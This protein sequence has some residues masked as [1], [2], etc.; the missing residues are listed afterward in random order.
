MQQRRDTASNWSSANPTL[1]AGEF[2]WDTTNSKLKVGDGS[3]AWNSLSYFS[4]G[5]ALTGG[6]MTGAILGDDSTSAA[7]PA[8]AF[9][10]DANTGMLRT[11]ADA[12]ALVTG[13][14]AAISIDSSQ[15][16]VIAGTLQVSG[17][18]TTVNSTTM[19]VADLNIEIAKGAAN[20]AAADGAGLTVDSGEGDKTWNWVNATDSWTSSEHIDIASGKVFKIATNTVLDANGAVNFNVTANNSTDETVYPVFVDGST[21]S[22][23]AETDTGLTYNPSTGTLTAT[24]FSGAFSGTSSTATEATNFTVTANNSTDESTYLVFVDG[25]TGTQGAET[26]TGLTYNPSSGNLSIGGELVAQSLDIS[27][28][29]DIDGILETDALTINGTTLSETIADTVG[30]MV[31]SNTETGITVTYEDSDNTLDFVIGTLNQDTTGTAANA[32]HVSVADNESTDENNLITFIENASATGNVGLESDGDFYY[33]PSTGRLTAT[34]LAGTLQTAAQ[35]NI[36]SVGSLTGLTIDGDLTFTGANYNV[37]W[38]KSDNALEFVDNAKAAFGTDGELSLFHNGSDSYIVDGGTGKLIIDA[39]EINFVKFGTS[40]VMAKFIEDGACESYFNGTKK[41]STQS[42]GL[43]VYGLIF[44]DD[45]LKASRGASGN[46]AHASSLLVLEDDANVVIQL[47]CPAANAQEI[48]F[49]DADDN[50]VGWMQYAH[51]SNTWSVGTNGTQRMYINSG[52]SLYV[53][54]VY[55][56]TT[57]SGANVEVSSGGKIR[58]STSSRRYKTNIETLE[59][60]YADAILEARP[61]WYKSICEDDNKDHGHWG[62]IAEE[63]E[64]IDPRLCTYKTVE[65]ETNRDEI[66]ETQLETPIVESVQYDRFVPHLINLIKRQ[67]TRINALESKVTA[68]ESA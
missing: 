57:G 1:L 14:T 13:G 42:Y 34:Q 25:A 19:T 49:G 28:N 54:G 62:F 67:D 18:T 40:E 31:S 12:L 30:A 20:D 48:R 23:G 41:T 27:G 47:L 22:Q 44:S 39:S 65:I 29:V 7:T 58:R 51:G 2:G 3:T 4:P 21:G 61:V 9:D 24:T 5:L 56:A 17:T 35:T 16:V 45:Y 43:D 50:G 8:Y 59:N 63:I 33:N 11:A 55:D 64:K 37:T 46:N 26:D 15:N 66:K 53:Q 10:G 6:T 36:T 52:G 60:K 68:L 38:D 32:T